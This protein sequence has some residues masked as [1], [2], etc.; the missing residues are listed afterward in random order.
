[1]KNFFYAIVALSFIYSTGTAQ[2]LD[3]QAPWM[4]SKKII[5][6]EERSVAL[7]YHHQKQA[8]DAWDSTQQK[9]INVG[10]LKLSYTNDGNESERI[11]L[12]TSMI[13]NSR[14]LLFYNAQNLVSEVVYQNKKI[15]GWAN[16]ARVLRAY[17]NSGIVTEDFYQ[18]WDSTTNSWINYRRLISAYD[19]HDQLTE[20]RTDDYENGN[21]VIKFGRKSIFEYDQDHIIKETGLVYNTTDSDWDTTYK[22]FSQFSDDLLDNAI[23]QVLDTMGNWINV[24]RQTYSHDSLGILREVKTDQ[25]NQIANE[26]RNYDLY[27][28]ITWVEWIGNENGPIIESY[29]Y[30][31]WDATSTS[32]V[33]NKMYEVDIP[34]NN[35]SYIITNESFKN[36]VWVPFDRQTILLDDH[37]NRTL[38]RKEDN[39]ND[40]WN[41]YFERNAEYTYDSL[42]RLTEQIDYDWD[43]L[44]NDTYKSVRTRYS[45]FK[46]FN[47]GTGTDKFLNT[48]LVYPNPAHEKTTIKFQT[49]NESLISIDVYN[50]MGQHNSTVLKNQFLSAG[51]HHY[52]IENLPKGIYLVRLTLD[53]KLITKKLVIQ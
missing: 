16:S 32:Y 34:D 8:N 20:R 38:F 7:I 25:Y 18:T 27:K 44:L 36:N 43:F 30:K 3:Q 13:E 6:Q 33:N 19:S 12:D 10:N 28:D 39:L 37:K 17:T 53:N 2:T 45:D 21:W 46:E 31:T 14:E 11:V 9:W 23:T 41:R 51:T 22:V 52:T 5:T 24:Q 42:S 4:A 48:L 35:G 29:L 49:S 1:M 47:T 15:T 40:Q 50:V 26:W